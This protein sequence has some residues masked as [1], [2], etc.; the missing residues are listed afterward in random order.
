MLASREN[1]QLNE[2]SIVLKTHR[3][4]L[5]GSVVKLSLDRPEVCGS[6]QARANSLVAESHH[7]VCFDLQ[8]FMVYD[9][10][11]IIQFMP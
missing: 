11:A 1:V 6:I 7:I 10:D 9:N 4:S 2:I 8:R 5:D 3:S